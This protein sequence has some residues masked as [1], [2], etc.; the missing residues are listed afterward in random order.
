MILLTGVVMFT[1]VLMSWTIRDRNKDYF[2]LYFLLLAG[3]FGVFS[4]L[5]LF[6]FSSST[7]LAVVPMYLLI[8]VW[9][10]STTFAPSSA[11]RSTPP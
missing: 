7:K 9:G 1:G 3:V 11:P 5:D 8:G 10:S 6:F 4:S 2:I